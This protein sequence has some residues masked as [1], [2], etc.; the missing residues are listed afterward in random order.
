MDP[1]LILQHE[2]NQGPGY[3][4]DYLCQQDIPHRLCHPAAGEPLPRSAAGLSGLVLLGS[5]HSANDEQLPWVAAELAL[6][7]DA[8][9]R[10]V[11]VL[12][13]CFGGQLL[14]RAL[15]A[16][17]QRNPLAQIGWCR[18]WAT[19]EAR[20]GLFG[21]APRPLSFNWHYEGFEIPRGAR[22]VLFGRHSL[23]KGFAA[24]PHLGL[25]CHLEVTPASVRAWCAEGRQELSRPGIAVQNEA[26]ML[27]DLEERCALLHLNAR[28]VYGSWAA[29]LP[30][31]RGGLFY[32]L[33][34]PTGSA[35]ALAATPSI[36]SAS[37][38]KAPRRLLE[39]ATA[40]IAAGPIRMPA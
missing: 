15:G 27:R 29:G 16:R 35:R 24:G 36:S 21:G 32:A 12:G 23:N 11:P 34:V 33:G 19:P 22:R 31:R 9:A 7:R 28:H 39:A 13:H 6:L 25:Q 5:N 40:P 3:L 38:M 17:V 37:P 4:L 26:E 1:V 30:R 2:P 18:L 14:A 20:A 10:D 8:V